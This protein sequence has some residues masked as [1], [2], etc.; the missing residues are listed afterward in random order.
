MS[1]YNSVTFILFQIKNMKKTLKGFTLV[2]V[3]IV[4]IIVGILIAALLP[5]LVG[6]QARSRDVARTAMVN[7]VANGIA[8]FLND[9][10]TIN[11]VNTDICLSAATLITGTVNAG[12]VDLSNFLASIPRDPQAGHTNG[13]G[14][15]GSAF[16]QISDDG[17]A[18][19]VYANFE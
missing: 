1:V 14:C 4:I 16:V 2:E 15:N 13:T 3:L 11:P 8:L 18:A 7:Q 19:L 10:G 9:A 12:T 5:R 17:R 6:S